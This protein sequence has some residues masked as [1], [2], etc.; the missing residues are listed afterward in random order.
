MKV[1]SIEKLSHLNDEY[2]EKS[3][4]LFIEGFGHIYSFIKDR[5][6]LKDFLLSSMD[7]SM[8]YVVLYQNNIVGFIGISNNEKRT[9]SFE[10]W[11]I[12]IQR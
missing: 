3:M 1:I 4:E 6:I 10:I 5:N 7:F 8:V 2:K 11:V 9:I 12:S